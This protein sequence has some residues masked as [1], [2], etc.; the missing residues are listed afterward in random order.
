MGRDPAEG[1]DRIGLRGGN[2]VWIR[3]LGL[4]LVL[5]KRMESVRCRG[6]CAVHC[7]GCL[8]IEEDC[9]L[10]MGNGMIPFRVWEVEIHCSF[11]LL[12]IK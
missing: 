3:G 7:A 11:L 4:L 8:A 9:V 5:E 2:A 1:W 12:V 6:R 10:G